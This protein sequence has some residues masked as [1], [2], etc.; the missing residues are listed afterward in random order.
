M[1]EDGEGEMRL[2]ISICLDQQIAGPDSITWHRA[3]DTMLQFPPRVENP[4]LVF[5]ARVCDIGLTHRHLSPGLPP[6]IEMM[7][8]RS[9]A[10]L[11]HEGFQVNDFL[12]HPFWFRLSENSLR[13]HR[14]RTSA[15]ARTG[16]LEF[17]VQPRQSILDDV[18]TTE[19]CP[20][21]KRQHERSCVCE[22]APGAPKP[23]RRAY[24]VWLVSREKKKA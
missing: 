13:W 23:N 8:N 4:I 24:E 14:M 17:V 10:L 16:R 9:T 15:P 22:G 20:A 12:Q 6:P 1:I 18:Q 21:N 2:S 11:R 19:K 3:W 7:R 5:S